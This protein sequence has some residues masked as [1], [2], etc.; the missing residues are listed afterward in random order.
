MYGHGLATIALCEAYGLTADPNLKRSAQSAINFIVQ[1]QDPVSG[2]WRDRPR[3]GGA[4]SVFGWQ[5]MA[6]KAGQMAGLSVP[7]ITLRGAEKWLDSVQEADG[8]GGHGYTSRE[9]TPTMT[10][11]GLLCREYLG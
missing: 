9:P 3:E 11:V 4:T 10:A 8:K 7:R 1:A 6:L 5:V 2:G